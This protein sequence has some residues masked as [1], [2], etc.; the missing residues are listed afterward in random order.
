MAWNHDGT[1]LASASQQGTM[2]RVHKL[3]QASKSFTFRWGPG[4]QGLQG[5]LVLL[6]LRQL[7]GL[8]AFAG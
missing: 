2:I 5:R 1:L 4:R 8:H 3:P 6:V 7:G